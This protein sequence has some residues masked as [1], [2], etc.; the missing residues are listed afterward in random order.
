ACTPV[1]S[2]SRLLSAAISV[3]ENF[4]HLPAM[5]FMRR[6]LSSGLAPVGDMEFMICSKVCVK[7]NLNVFHSNYGHS[8]CLYYGLITVLEYLSILLRCAI[9]HAFRAVARRGSG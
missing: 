2:S 7:N 1:T 9:R 3:S 5:S 6:F 8:I 4:D